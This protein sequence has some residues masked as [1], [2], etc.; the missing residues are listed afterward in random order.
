MNEWKRLCKVLTFFIDDNACVCCIDSLSQQLRMKVCQSWNSE[1]NFMKCAVI[2]G[3]LVLLCEFFNSWFMTGVCWRARSHQ[4]HVCQTLTKKTLCVSHS[5][6][7][8]TFFL[9]VLQARMSNIEAWCCCS[10][11]MWLQVQVVWSACFWDFLLTLQSF[12]ETHM[13]WAGLCSFGMFGP[14]WLGDSKAFDNISQMSTMI[15]HRT[16]VR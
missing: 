1:E 9:L 6:R 7:S 4:F 10:G 16:S 5:L 8:F 15:F 13:A 14:S 2:L 3:F 12:V 11:N